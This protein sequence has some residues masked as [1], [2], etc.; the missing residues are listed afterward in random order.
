VVDDASMNWRINAWNMIRQDISTALPPSFVFFV[1][2]V[3]NN[4]AL[5]FSPFPFFRSVTLRLLQTPEVLRLLQ[6]APLSHRERGDMRVHPK[7]STKASPS[8]SIRGVTPRP[9]V[10]GAASRPADR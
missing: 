8:T 2:F 6:T 1:L 10:L 9:G 7:T 4:P 5:L 3:V